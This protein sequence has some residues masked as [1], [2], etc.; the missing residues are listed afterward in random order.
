MGDTALAGTALAGTAL[1]ETAV[2]PGDESLRLEE[3]APVIGLTDREVRRYRRFFGL[4]RVRWSPDRELAGLLT[5]AARNLAGLPGN[6][7]RVRFV[8]HA[9]TLEAAAPYS[10]HPLHRA[11]AEL[12]LGHAPAFV[13]SQHACASGL[14][15]VRLAGRLLA[16]CG[17]PA[18]LALVLT[19]EKTYPHVTRY[20]PATTVMGE[21]SAACLVGRGGDRDRVLGYTTVTRGE[22]HRMAGRGAASGKDFEDAYP[23]TLA[24]LVRA[25]AKDAGV[26][27]DD[28]RLILPHNVNRI[29]WTRTCKLA[30]LPLDRLW[31]DNVPV[32]GHCFCADPFV[33]LAGA[34]AAGALRPGDLYLMVSVGLGATFSALVLRH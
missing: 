11:A 34:V 27:L 4:D 18:A 1:V 21:A 20:I 3:I 19:G 13:V 23:G 31:L 30:G 14:L 2:H 9:R 26:S 7:H 10:A 15:A 16:G 5:G 22:F 8:L 33:N 29:S 25:A 6:E 17:D 24:D 12:G 28:V 32:T